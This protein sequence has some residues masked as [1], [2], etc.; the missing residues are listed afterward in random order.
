MRSTGNFSPEW[1]Y[2]APA[3]SILR[4]VRVVLVATA[5]APRPVPAWCCRWST[6][7]WAMASKVAAA[8]HAIVAPA[9][10]PRLLQ[11]PT[12]SEAKIAPAV[13]PVA[14]TPA[15][16]PVQA[17]ALGQTP[18]QAQAVPQIQT[19]PQI[20]A[21][22]PDN[23]APAIAPL[24]RKMPPPRRRRRLRCTSDASAVAAPPQP[25]VA[26]LSD[27]RCRPRLLRAPMR[28]AI[29]AL[30]GRSR[31]CQQKKTKHHNSAFQQRISPGHGAAA[32]VQ[33][34][35]RHVVL[36]KSRVLIAAVARR[37]AIHLS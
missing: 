25:A 28:P 29:K 12:M 37:P 13:A 15:Q 14:Q 36:S 11:A 3:P 8:A 22:A 16:K 26:A 20:Q 34:A 18:P 32:P 21:A 24:R 19:A 5:S 10:K 1:G 2:L 23:A 33:R 9:C 35:R 31:P 30:S 7:P 17:A 4:T 6:I 27:V